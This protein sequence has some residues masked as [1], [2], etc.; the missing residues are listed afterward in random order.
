ML[1]V[2]AP[3]W[4]WRPSWGHLERMSSLCWAKNGVFIWES[5]PLHQGPDEHAF[6]GSCEAHVGVSCHGHFE[7]IWGFMEVAG[8]LK[9]SQRK[10]FLLGVFWVLLGGYIGPFWAMWGPCWGHAGAMCDPCWT[11]VGPCCRSYKLCFL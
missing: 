6:F 11:D 5:G 3:C 2:F 9:N 8:G 1:L 4:A 7:A 10:N